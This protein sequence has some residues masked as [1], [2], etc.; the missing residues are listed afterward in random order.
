MKNKINME[1]IERIKMS[2]K[3]FKKL[4][5][6]F[7][8]FT[9][10]FGLIKNKTVIYKDRLNAKYK[11]R[12]GTADRMIITEV[13]VDETY[14]PKGFEINSQDIVLDIG[15]Q[16]GIFSV[17]AS[18]FAKEGKIFSFEPV[19]ENFEGLKENIRI[20]DSKNITPLQVAI[21]DRKGTKNLF[22]S[23]NSGGHSF[24]ESISRGSGKK[25]KVSTISLNDFIKENKIKKV[26]Y[27]K[28]DC[29]GAEYSILFSCYKKI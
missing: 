28:M 26:D 3:V 16:V 4:K 11:V 5:T 10:Y 12:A 1:F 19:P 7:L 8:F 2:V 17:F 21:S 15:A 25:V 29:E 27:L 9:D 20:N 23:E 13:C 18:K 6:P 14:N 22:I 24:Y